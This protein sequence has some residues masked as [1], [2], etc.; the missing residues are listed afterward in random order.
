MWISLGILFESA[1]IFECLDFY[2]MTGTGTPSYFFKVTFQLCQ[3]CPF[4]GG[5]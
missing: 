4:L 5:Q 2:K 3:L 1:L